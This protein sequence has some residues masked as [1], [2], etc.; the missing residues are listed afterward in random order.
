MSVVSA[1]LTSTGK[2]PASSYV[3]VGLLLE[4]PGTLTPGPTPQQLDV[5][6]DCTGQRLR[7]VVIAGLDPVPQ[8]ESSPRR[9]TLVRPESGDPAPAGQ[10]LTERELEVL[11]HLSALLTTEE[12]AAAMFISVNTVKT[13]VRGILRKLAVSR[14]NEAVRHARALGIV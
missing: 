12:I 11:R 2:T 1:P 9:L 13:H 8:P 4:S 3:L 6:L 5:L 7:L 14:R 10:A